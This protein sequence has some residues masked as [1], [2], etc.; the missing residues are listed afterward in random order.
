MQ[1]HNN[2]SNLQ[3]PCYIVNKESF[4]NNYFKIRRAFERCWGTKIL[5]GYSVKTNHS[6]VLLNLAKENGMWAEVVSDDEYNW[7]KQCGYE[8]QEIIFNGPQKSAKLLV[9]S[10]RTGSIVNLDNMEDVRVLIHEVSQFQGATIRVG[11][12]VNFD[13][14]AEC[15]GETTAGDEVSRFGFCLENGELQ[16]AI[17]ELQSVSIIVS[18]LHMHYSSKSRSVNIFQ[19]LA[20]KAAE[21]VKE[22]HLEQQIEYIDIGGGFFM[23]EPGMANGRPEMMDYAEAITKELKKVLNPENVAL[24][25]EPGA[26]LLATTVNYLTRVINER[27]IRG[28]HVL[29]VDGSSLHVNPFM[30][31]R[32]P[33]YRILTKNI[34]RKICRAKQIICGSTCM[35]NDRLAVV[36]EGDEIT[37]GDYVY[38]ACAG[39]YTMGFNSCF[40]NLPPYIYIKDKDE[41]YLIREKDANALFYA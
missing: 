35:E 41:F 4:S 3:T 38:C 33:I 30:A 21:V 31:H 25:L 1:L 15:P 19:A 39:A 40:I 18:G 9:D 24:I 28:V 7:A 23:G 16:E 12:R 37:K 5:M 22:N 29:T 6:E 13:L 34:E 32:E 26:S 14:E 36:Q 11:L 8:P 17:R 2:I 27:I 20:R 10:V